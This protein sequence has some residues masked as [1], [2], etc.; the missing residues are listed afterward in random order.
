M[1]MEWDPRVLLGVAL[2]LLLIGVLLPLLEVLQ[3]LESTFFW[4]FL[5]FGASFLGL[6]LGIIGSVSY[7]VRRKGK[8]K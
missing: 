2:F 1:M 7:M 8:N 6:M 3:I 4:N 5:A